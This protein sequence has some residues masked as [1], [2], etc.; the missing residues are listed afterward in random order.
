MRSLLILT[1]RFPYPVIGGDRLRIYQTLPRARRPL[2]ADPAQ[3][4][5]Y[6][7][8]M[9]MALPDDGVFHRVE[10]VFLPKWRSWLNTPL[11]LPSRTPLQ[12]AYY[13]HAGFR[14]RALALMAEHDGTLAHLIRV[15][16]VI[17]DA[18]GVK[19]LEMTD[20]IS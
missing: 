7:E 2:S 8:E 20:A 9:A 1:P 19:F 18:P 17:K 10:H 14:R 4:V 15:G 5:R 13:R 3:L 16:D 11:A 12:V 6:P